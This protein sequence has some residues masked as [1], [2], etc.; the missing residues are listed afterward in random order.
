[1][2][3][4]FTKGSRTRSGSILNNRRARVEVCVLVKR[5]LTL[6]GFVSRLS[7]NSSQNCSR[8]PAI[9]LPLRTF[10]RIR[11]VLE[12][13]TVEVFLNSVFNPCPCFNPMSLISCSRTTPYPST[14]PIEFWF[15]SLSNSLEMEKKF[16]SLVLELIHLTR[17]KYFFCSIK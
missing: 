5:N 1:M 15:Y 12:H 3:R 9:F 6:N 8:T 7:S 16:Y 14:L 13:I 17:N 10:I 11:N 4:K 2:K